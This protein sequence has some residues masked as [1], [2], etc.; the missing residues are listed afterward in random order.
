M[1]DNSAIAG[2]FGVLAN[3]RMGLSE[4]RKNLEASNIFREVSFS[5]EFRKYE[6]SVDERFKTVLE[7]YLEAYL[8]NKRDEGDCL[9]WWLDVTFNGSQWVLEPSVTWDGVEQILKLKNRMVA[10]D[11]KF[12]QELPL[13]LEELIGTYNQVAKKVGFESTEHLGSE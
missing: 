2:L 3:A 9:V 8:A 13:V 5:I 7:V 1:D 12:L 11:E 4:F 10:T 6:R